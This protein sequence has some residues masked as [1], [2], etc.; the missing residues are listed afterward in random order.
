MIQFQLISIAQNLR[1]LWTHLEAIRR[2]QFLMLIFLIVATSFAEVLSIGSVI[3]FLGALTAP[4]RIFVFPWLQPIIHALNITTPREIIFPLAVLFGFAAIFSGGMRIM[5]LYF[6]TRLSYATGADLGLQMYRIALYQPYLVHCSRNSSDVI[7]G[8]TAKANIVTSNIVVP[9]LTLIGSFAILFGV[10]IAL[11]LI[12][13]TLTLTIFFVF[14]FIYASIS[15]FY[16]KK[17]LNNSQIISDNSAR[18]LKSLQEGFGGIRDILINGAQEGYCNIYRTAD[19][20]LRQAQGSNLFIGASPRYVVESLG[21]LLIAAL[22]FILVGKPNGIYAAIPI[23]GVLALAAQRILPVLQQIYASWSSI[24]AGQAPLRSA[25]DLLA[26]HP[27]NFGDLRSFPPVLFQENITLRDVSFRYDG[28]GSLAL[29]NL[30]FKIPKGGTIGFIGATGSGKS[31]LLDVVMGLLEPSDGKL[32]VDGVAITSKNRSAWQAHIAHVPQ[33]IFLSDST[34]EENIAFGVVSE[35]IDFER[36][37]FAATQAHLIETI[38]AL[39][40]KYQT[41][42]GERGIKLS[43][44]QR[45][46]I[47]IARALYKKSDVI[48]FDEATSALDNQT[49]QIIMEAIEQLSGHMTIL[50]IAHRLTTLKSCSQVVEIESGSIKRVGSYEQVA[51]QSL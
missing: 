46:R 34:I 2:W 40:E 1:S 38:E 36:V 24:Q 15:Y 50:I 26:Q 33:S 4:E 21:M 22:A 13:P 25:L 14:G 20:E 37:R 44:G 8:I 39:P 27:E 3:P 9:T 48:I 18:V 51:L 35:E 12:E 7:D 41:M 16:S 6:T 29:K 10:L 28:F 49:E 19:I 5:L 17:L 32:E 43:G 31:T 45:Q 23:L 47:G 42:V 30:T 11:V